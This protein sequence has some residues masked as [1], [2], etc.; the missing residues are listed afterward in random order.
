MKTKDIGIQ[1]FTLIELLV[2]IAIIAILAAML[3]PALNKAR[4]KARQVGCMNNMRQMYHVFL[5][6]TE[7][8]N[9]EIFTWVYY[10]KWWGHTIWEAGA[11]D[12]IQK[13]QDVSGYPNLMK[14][15]SVVKTGMRLDNGNYHCGVSQRVSRYWSAAWWQGSI[16]MGSVKKPTEVGWYADCTTSNFTYNTSEFKVDFRHSENANVLFVAGQV[17]SR[18][19]GS[20]PYQGNDTFYASN[21][22]W[23]P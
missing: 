16:K 9:D 1:K 3:L 2:V 19:R 11:F 13:I 17:E 21:I 12:G 7:S 4:E 22:F 10:T 15:P 23:N 8:N 6:Y 20:I 14:C 5:N 18:R